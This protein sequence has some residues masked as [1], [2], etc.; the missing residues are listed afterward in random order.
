MHAGRD[1]RADLWLSTLGV[2]SIRQML[3]VAADNEEAV[4]AWNGVL[5]DRFVEFRH[6][7]AA[8]LLPHGSAALRLAPP[9]PGDRV[10][11]VG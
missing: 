3:E 11:D 7:V 5:F 6:I 2:G 4:R 8:G 1:G 10:L 9:S